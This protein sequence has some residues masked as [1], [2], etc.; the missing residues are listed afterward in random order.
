[1][2]N[3]ERS[4]WMMYGIRA[5]TCAQLMAGYQWRIYQM[6]AAVALRHERA[7]RGNP[8]QPDSQARAV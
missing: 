7:S 1:M 6:R 3:L 8:P 5:D 4:M 2:T